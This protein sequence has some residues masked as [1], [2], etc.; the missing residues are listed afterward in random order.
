M[1]RIPGFLCLLILVS[2]L[3]NSCGKN[4]SGC[5]PNPV[6]N[7]KAQL[8]AYCT[9]NNITYTEDGSGM[10]YQIIDPGSGVAPTST[11]TVYV[12][13]TGKFLN[14]N[15]FDATANPVGLSLTGVIDGWK[16]GLPL[17]KKGGRIKLIIPSALAYS[18]AGFPPAI[19]ANTPL[20]F[21]ITLTDVK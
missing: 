4:D 18:C 7:E 6:A 13:Y 14:G 9:S 2:M 8:V 21:D 11:S 16:I 1:K 5:Q 17:I 15:T 19:P 3:L 10:L 20:Y 12:V